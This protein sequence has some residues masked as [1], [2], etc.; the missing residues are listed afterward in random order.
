MVDA[1]TS[2]SP[3][4]CSNCDRVSRSPN[5]HVALTPFITVGTAACTCARNA[6]SVMLGAANVGSTSAQRAHLHNS[7]GRAQ[8]HY[9]DITKQ[10]PPLRNNKQPA[11]DDFEVITR[12]FPP[13]FTPIPTP[14]AALVPCVIQAAYWQRDK[15]PNREHYRTAG[16]SA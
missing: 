6:A 16:A 13:L 5:A 2:T 14:A 7:P 10:N 3:A 9:H 11:Q 8:A 4:A 12:D 1:S 15:L